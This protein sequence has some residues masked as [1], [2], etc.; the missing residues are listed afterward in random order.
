MPKKGNG[1]WSRAHWWGT[2]ILITTI[3]TS[4]KQLITVHWCG[5]GDGWVNQ[6]KHRP[7]LGLESL[8]TGR[9]S[10][11]AF[12]SY[13]FTWPF[14]FG[15]MWPK[16]S[17]SHPYGSSVLL[18]LFFLTI[19]DWRVCGQSCRELLLCHTRQGI[20]SGH[21]WLCHLQGPVENENSMPQF[22]NY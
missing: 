22:K 9:H 5:F 18:S 19:Q 13:T 1:K 21:T 11:S 16:H 3:K 14:L 6:H 17:A 7:V 10:G 12:S 8:D 20:T 2:Q 15:F 4:P